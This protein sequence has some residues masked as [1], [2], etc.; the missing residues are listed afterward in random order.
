M[1]QG[2]ARQTRPSW[3]PAS[4]AI[5]ASG[6]GRADGTAAGIGIR[7]GSAHTGN[8]RARDRGTGPRTICSTS[9]LR[10]TRVRRRAAD[11]TAAGIGIR[12]SC[13]ETGYRRAHGKWT[14]AR[15]TRAA[16]GSACSDSAGTGRA[17]CSGGRSAAHGGARLAALRHAPIASTTPQGCQTGLVGTCQSQQASD[18][19]SC[20]ARRHLT[21]WI[22]HVPNDTAICVPSLTPP[23]LE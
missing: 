15:S 6:V 11:G 12:L 20:D 3:P 16:D 4:F 14:P 2:S 18:E 7:L 22:L 23:F 21:H 9:I 5:P 17:T 1:A 13:A 8:C 19:K 10:N